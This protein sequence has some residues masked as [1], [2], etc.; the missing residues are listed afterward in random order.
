MDKT[1]KTDE[2]AVDLIENASDVKSESLEDVIGGVIGKPN[3]C[4][5]CAGQFVV[6]QCK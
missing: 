1:N 6:C 5:N 3:K 4:K 2:N